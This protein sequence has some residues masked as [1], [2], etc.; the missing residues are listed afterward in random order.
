MGEIVVNIKLENFVDQD[1]FLDSKIPETAIR[2]HDMQAV[3]DT[4]A[5]TLMLPQEV[6]DKLGLRMVGEVIVVYADERREKRSM[7]GPVSLKIGDRSMIA[8]CI[9]GPPTSEA[10]IGQIIM[11]R[12]DLIADCANQTLAPRPESPILPLFSLK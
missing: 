5:R 7:A 1:H 9:V 6:V 12:L 11:E 3:V 8:E 4:G 2:R 10:L